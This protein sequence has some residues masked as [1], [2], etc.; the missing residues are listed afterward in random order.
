MG[1]SGERRLCNEQLQ[2]VRTDWRVRLKCGDAGKVRSEGLGTSAHWPPG[3]P[4]F[5]ELGVNV[6]K[7][8]GFLTSVASLECEKLKRAS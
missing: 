5:F 1:D 4:S 3:F 6:L 7:V 8:R 2:G